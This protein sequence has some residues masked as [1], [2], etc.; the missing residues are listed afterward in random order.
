[1]QP[2]NLNLSE[3]GFTLIELLVSATITILC[4]L[5]I[6][7]LLRKGREI[8]INDRYRRYA[9]ALV[10]SEFENPRFNFTQYT[11]L[12]T[13]AGTTS[14][15]VTIDDRGPASDITGTMRTTI[16]AQTT[17]T[18]AN[19]TV[20]PYIPVT[21]RVSWNTVDGADTVSVAKYIT[22]AQ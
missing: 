14:Q 2:K 21:I 17:M 11:N 16:G 1:M 20:T 5:S 18:A 3:K 13:Q 4:I 19:G 8:D 15:A 12:L 22:Q 6:V 7:V 10:V 9:R